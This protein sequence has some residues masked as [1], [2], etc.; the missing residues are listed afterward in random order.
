MLPLGGL[1]AR[2]KLE[3]DQMP[4]KS[5]IHPS[6]AVFLIRQF[7]QFYFLVNPQVYNFI[8]SISAIT[9]VS[10][11]RYIWRICMA[12]HVAPRLLASWT[13]RAH[14]RGLAHIVPNQKLSRYHTLISLAYWLHNVELFSL[15]AVTYVSNKENYRKSSKLFFDVSFKLFSFPRSYSRKMLLHILNDRYMQHVRTGHD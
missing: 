1:Y 13:Y 11:Q 9:G 3:S 10:P 4:C 7:S 12:F 15:V 6:Y 2:G 5:L 14:Y 8:P